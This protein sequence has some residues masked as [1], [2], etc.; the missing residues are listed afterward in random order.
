MPL[1]SSMV[2][3]QLPP[4]DVVLTARSALAFAAAIGERA[5]LAERATCACPLQCVSL[6]WKVVDQPER[7]T[8]LSQDEARRF[9]HAGQASTFHAPLPVG[10][11]YRVSGRIE[12]VRATRAGA[13]TRTR[14]DVNDRETGVL[15]S[16]TLSTAIAR[17]VEVEGEDRG[18]LDDTTPSGDFEVEH[19]A[20]VEIDPWFS[21][22][23]T[24]CADIW[25]PIHTELAVALAAGLP[26]LIV[27]GTALWALAGREIAAR[28]AA[29]RIDAIRALSGRF[30]AMV[31]P[32]T[33]VTVRM[34]WSTD[35]PATI[36]FALLNAEGR[37][38]VSAGVAR[39]A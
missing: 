20:T 26:G 14:L 18:P 2:G 31:A 30:S 35:D 37:P 8:G 12:A 22:R 25:N 28:Y 13:L 33:T 1:S 36:L 16:S 32:G 17:G 24:E 10:H 19:E 3:S 27:H 11:A 6:E 9:V 39:L 34:G 15:V 7:R 23:Y 29:G 5:D 38:A 4:A 21:H